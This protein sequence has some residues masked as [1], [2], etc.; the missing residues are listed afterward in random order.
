M[1]FSKTTTTDF[2][3]FWIG[4]ANKQKFWTNIALNHENGTLRNEQLLKMTDQELEK[5]CDNGVNKIGEY[6]HRPDNKAIAEKQGGSPDDVYLGAHRAQI[7][8]DYRREKKIEEAE[9]RKDNNAE[10][11]NA[12]LE[13][14]F[15]G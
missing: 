3:Q 6:Y 12:L 13:K 4:I 10:A 8:L 11:F 14:N 1:S 7:I 2:N 9:Q 15:C 5:I